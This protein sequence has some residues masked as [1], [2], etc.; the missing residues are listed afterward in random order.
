MVSLLRRR[1]MMVQ[2]GGGETAPLYP[3]V[4]GSFTY[5]SPSARSITIEGGNRFAYYNP[6]SASGGSYVNISKI[7]QNTSNANDTSN[8]NNQPALFTI[9]ANSVVNVEINP[10]EFTVFSGAQSWSF[11]F[12]DTSSATISGLSITGLKDQPVSA[13]VTIPSSEKVGCIFFYAS[14]R[15][16]SIAANISIVINGIRYV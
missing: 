2:A 11:G 4:N 3:L 10:T 12:R 5:S 6:R 14:G 16:Q 13:S 7:A 15:I 9:P 1:A 8:I